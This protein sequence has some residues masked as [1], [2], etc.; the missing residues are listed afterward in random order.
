MM[1]IEKCTIEPKCDTLL[2]LPGS[3]GVNLYDSFGK[4]YSTTIFT[5]CLSIEKTFIFAVSIPV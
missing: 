2:E 5:E 3:Y 1:L 4:W